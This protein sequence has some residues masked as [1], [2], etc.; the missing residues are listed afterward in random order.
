MN[1]TLPAPFLD[2][3]RQ[4]L[5]RDG[6]LETPEDMAP[7]LREWRDRYQG[8]TPLVLRPRTTEE[9]ADAMTLCARYK[10]PVTPQ[11]GNTG[12]VGA[13]IPFGDTVLI[14]LS[15]MDRI[16]DLDRLNHTM[17]V[18]AGCVLAR[19]QQ[20]ALEADLYFPLSLAAEG[21]CQIGGNLS[22]N[23]GGVNVLHYGNA[24]DQVL[25]LEVVLADGQVW[26]S[27]K[28]LRKDN[29]GY[30]LKHLFIGGE[31]TLGIIT[32]ATLKL[33]ARPRAQATALAGVDGPEAAVRLLSLARQVSGDR[34]TSFELMARICLDFVLRNGPDTAD[35]LATAHPWYVLLEL[36]SDKPVMETLLEE[37]FEAGLV[38]DAVIA[39]SLT[40][41][42]SLW[43]L[44]ELISEAQK[45]EGGS[46]KHDVSVPVSKVPAF[47]AEAD[48]AVA[49]A[50]PGI[51]PVPF[52]HVGDGNIHYNLTQPPGADKAA[53]LDR[54]EEI[55]GIV[56][57]IATAHGGSISAEHGIGVMKRDALRGVKSPVELDMMR[58]IKAALDPDGLMNPGKLL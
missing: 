47:I 37:A 42:A 55:S 23:A 10:V 3:L 57:G 27:L 20:A 9:V 54:W 36:S 16:R 26:N 1:L 33:R 38:K 21:S 51:R 32:A 46:I 56:H 29:T 45:P 14:S 22:S 15:R 25:G 11:G 18:E 6:V 49:A 58:K 48:E 43:R 44:R 12:L 50:C 52:G 28:G 31:G 40:Q 39:E 7:Y 5:G 4:C 35:P 13:Q 53:F 30:D 34:V 19:I 24:R 17:T 41:A 2:G 8:R